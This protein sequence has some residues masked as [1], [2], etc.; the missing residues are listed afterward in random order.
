MARKTNVKVNDKDYFRVRA[1]VFNK[2]G[3]K[4][5]KAFYGNQKKKRRKKEMSTWLGSPVG[6]L[7]ILIKFYSGIFFMNG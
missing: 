7:E 6:F 5:T 2:Y 4:T 3:E 1:T